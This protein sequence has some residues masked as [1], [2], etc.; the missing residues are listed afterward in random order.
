MGE[1]EMVCPPSEVQDVPP[2]KVSDD[3]GGFCWDERSDIQARSWF[4]DSIGF[5]VNDVGQD[6]GKLM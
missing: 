6:G 2:S 5:R 3:G 4:G 1:S